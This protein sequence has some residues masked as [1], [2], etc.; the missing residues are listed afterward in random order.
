MRDEINLSEW[1]VTTNIKRASLH[2]ASN[3]STKEW[4]KMTSCGSL[5]GEGKSDEY[6]YNYTTQPVDTT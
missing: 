3:R 1:N 2:L 6:Y 5:A 4:R